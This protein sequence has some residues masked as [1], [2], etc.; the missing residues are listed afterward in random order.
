M[1]QEIQALEDNRM[2]TLKTFS[3]DKK[4]LG[5]LWVYKIKYNSDGTIERYKARLVIFKNKQEEGIYC[6]ETFAPVATIVTFGPSWHLQLHK[7]E[8]WMF[9][10]PS[11]MVT[12]RRKLT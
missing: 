9:I 5:C 4:K 10:M 2:W 7:I 11:Y 1:Q 8:R 12:L 6:N 3:P